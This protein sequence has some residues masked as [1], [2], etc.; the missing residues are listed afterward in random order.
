[1]TRLGWMSLRLTAIA[2]LTSFGGCGGGTD[3][4]GFLRSEFST[5]GAGTLTQVLLTY[6][7]AVT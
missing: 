4:L 6:Y 1:M 5:I 2:Y 3:F 7:R